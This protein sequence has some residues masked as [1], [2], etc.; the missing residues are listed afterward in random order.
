MSKLVEIPFSKVMAKAA[1]DGRKVCTSRSEVKGDL[2]DTFMIEGKEFRI[3]DIQRH[4]L[5]SV[6]SILFRQEGVNTPEE[7]E[8]LWK[9]LHRGHYNGSNMVFVHFFARVSV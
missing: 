3:V 4:R 8:E 6:T 1:L 2:G 9:S 7:F 5:I